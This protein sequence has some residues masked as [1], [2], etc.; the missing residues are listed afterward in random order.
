MDEVAAAWKL[1]ALFGSSLSKEE[2]APFNSW[3][4]PIK[5][6]MTPRRDADLKTTARSFT[7]ERE[8]FQRLEGVSFPGLNRRLFHLNA[9]P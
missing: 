5:T 8:G 6:F 3:K 1:P 7:D 4:M 9:L 2:F